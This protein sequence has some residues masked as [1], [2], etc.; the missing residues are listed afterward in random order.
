MPGPH[1]PTQVSVEYPPPQGRNVFPHNDILVIF[2]SYGAGALNKAPITI[3]IYA[4]LFIT[5][6]K[7]MSK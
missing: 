4:A 2:T 6:N 7:F 1:L 5:D 3:L